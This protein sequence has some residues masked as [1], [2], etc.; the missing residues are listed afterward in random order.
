[1]PVNANSRN[2]TIWTRLTHPLKRPAGLTLVAS[3]PQECGSVADT[4]TTSVAWKHDQRDGF[5]RA[6]W[7]VNN[8]LP[9]RSRCFHTGGEESL[10]INT[11][12][13]WVRQN[14]L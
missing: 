3:Q 10:I 13:C 11:R 8:Y 12:D 1:M 14:I 9:H 5:L 6:V 2:L 7:A 4:P